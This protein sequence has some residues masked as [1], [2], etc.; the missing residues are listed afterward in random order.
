MSSATPRDAGKWDII[1]AHASHAI[2]GTA[3]IP[4]VTRYYT[5]MSAYVYV[6][7]ELFPTLARQVLGQ[8]D[9]YELTLTD[10]LVDAY[11]YSLAFRKTLTAACKQQSWDPV[12]TFMMEQDSRS[13]ADAVVRY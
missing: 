6:L 4:F 10:T 7:E 9:G 2:K 1:K 3:A 11:R 5:R 13:T 8:I 12:G